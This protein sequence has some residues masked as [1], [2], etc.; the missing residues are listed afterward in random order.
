MGKT[1][2]ETLEEKEKRL[3]EFEE[4]LNMREKKLQ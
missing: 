3:K 4:E 2:K 1:K